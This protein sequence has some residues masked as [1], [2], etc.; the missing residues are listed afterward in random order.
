MERFLTA[1]RMLDGAMPGHSCRQTL[2][3]FL[4]GS[5]SNLWECSTSLSTYPKSVKRFYPGVK[6][7][8]REEG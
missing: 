7:W 3:S 8:Y 2:A 4:L 5:R 6:C 1:S